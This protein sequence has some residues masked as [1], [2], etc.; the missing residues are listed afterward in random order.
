MFGVDRLFNQPKLLNPVW[1]QTIDDY[2]NAVAWSP[3]GKQLAVASVSGPIFV[4]DLE[5]GRLRQSL[6]GHGFGTTAIEWSRCGKFF[7]SVGQDGKAKLWDIENERERHILNA[8]N[9]WVEHLAWSSHTSSGVPVFAT[10]AG[11]KLNLWSAH[12][13]LLLAYSDHP[14]TISDIQWKPNSRTPVLTSA[15]YGQVALWAVDSADP[16][17]VLTWKGSI[18]VLQWS[19][20]GKHIATGDQD[21]TVHFWIVRTGQDLQMYGYPTKVRELSWDATGRYLAT[22]GSPVITIWDC[23]GRGPEGSKPQEMHG[24]EQLLSA[25]AYQRVGSLLASGG[26]DG[27][28]LVWRPTRGQYPLSLTEMTGDITQLA[29]SPNDR[30]LAAGSSTGEI[31]LLKPGG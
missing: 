9:A 30:W 25:L 5:S 29:W 16:L 22:G 17:Q 6:A 11:K 10:A 23:S 21:S 18:L 28:V 24:H 8:G 12:G 27:K 2:V 1:R 4:F 13:E 3:D 15:T 7:A 14:S 31:V 26:Q 20:D 19:P